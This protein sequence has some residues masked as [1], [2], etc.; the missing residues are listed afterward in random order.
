MKA[1]IYTRVSTFD[2]ANGYSLEMQEKLAMSYC[3]QHDIEV[4]KHYSDEITGAKMD[5]PSLRQLLED[6]E[7]RCFNFVIVHKLDRLSRSQ[8]DTL[9]IIEDIFLK[10]EI[11]FISLSE[12]FDTRTP[13][14]KALVGMLAVFAQFERDQIR[15]RMQLGKLGR[16]SQ[17]KPMTWSPPFCPFGYD[18]IDGQYKVNE[19]SHWVRYIFDRFLIGD[20]ITTIAH[21]MTDRKVLNKKWYYTT[22]KW[23]LE[24]PVYIGKIRWRGELYQGLHSPIILEEVY[25][26]AQRKIPITK[27]SPNLFRNTTNYDK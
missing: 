15:E 21:D 8:K 27:K 19:Y 26:E 20:T 12:N 7:N 24:N 3:Q 23:I 6:A 16:A 10:N 18:Y 5:R 25:Y 4:Y 1:A 22:V 2:Q 13:V 14:G 9:H 17:G 11:N